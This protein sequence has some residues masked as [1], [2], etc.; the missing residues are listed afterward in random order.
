MP[1]ETKRSNARSGDNHVTTIKKQA[2]TRAPAKS[3]AWVTIE[4]TSP[5]RIHTFSCTLRKPFKVEA[6]KIKQY[7]ANGRVDF[8]RVVEI[9]S[10]GFNQQVADSFRKSVRQARDENKRVLGVRDRA[11]PKSMT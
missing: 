11:P 5:A 10:E 4:V 6:S 1:E 8:V 9:D 7:K 2:T 3:G